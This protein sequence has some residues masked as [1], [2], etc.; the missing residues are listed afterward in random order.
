[1]SVVA[2][3]LRGRPVV[4]HRPW[5][6]GKPVQVGAIVAL[7][8]L[9]YRA[10]RLDYAW[11]SSLVWNQLPFHFD[12]F[13]IWLLDRR[14]AEDKSVVFAVFDGFRVFVD[15]LVGWFTELLFD[16]TWVGTVAAGTLIAL[17]FGGV[18]AAFWVLGAFAAF[19]LMGLWEESIQTLAL[20]LVA[21]ALSL[22]VG[23]PVGILA[24]RSRRIARAI[25]PALDAMQ[26]VPAFA[27]LMPVVILFSVGSA[28]AVVATM[29]YAIPPAV[30]ITALGIRRVPVN[31]VEAAASMGSTELQVLT[32]VQL[33]LARRMLLLGVN[34][35]ILF[36]L[37]MVVIAA[38]I[39]GAGLGAV[40]TRGLASSPA[41]A[42][43]GGIAIVVMAMA[44]DRATESVA[45][46]TDPARRHLDDRKRRRLR[47]WTIATAAA[48]GITV[49][50]ARLAGAPGI[51]PDTFGS[52][53][54]PRRAN[55][56]EWLLAR[57]QSVLDRVQDPAGFVFSVTEPTG[58]FILQKLLLPLQQFLVEGPWFATVAGLTA[59]AFV[60]SGLRPAL[61]TLAMLVA[62]GVL[63]VWPLAMDTLS[64]V[65]VATL[66]AIVLGVLLGI[67][68]AESR[69]VSMGLRP[70]ND[71]LQTLP[72][73]VY[74]VPFIYLMPVSIVPGIVA[75]VL[76]AFPVAARL[77][78]RGIRDVAPAPV[79]AADAFGATRAQRLVKV[80]V[81]LAGD[82][83]MLGV[84]QAI[85]MVLAVV[86][87]GGLVG[88]GG[89][90]YEVAQGLVRGQFGQGVV[91]SLA[92][93]ALG[94]ALDRV[95][96]GTRRAR[97]EG[98]I[99]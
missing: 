67:W 57:I 30:R 63:G 4:A 69:I 27:Y 79:E 80:K 88:S 29:I 61:T 43:L 35:T 70:V 36:A 85:I 51:Y 8:Y 76:Y 13:Q 3:R 78:E 75:G 94:I 60:V 74:I 55:A 62:I 34:Q 45:N 17:R 66:M 53:T 42:I 46:R 39:G 54:S 9:A 44:L 2:E 99:G 64:Q 37:S 22:L 71:V 95:T 81:P 92:I 83:I 24:G 40:V 47:L 77:V 18:R 32:K 68:A 90:G 89:L 12:E 96:Q 19:A 31:T 98:A 56:E 6:R 59:I 72:Q 84:N 48:V 58:I 86:V 87:I 1:V 73:L 23:M 91:A 38:L 7:M 33:P 20:M 50:V 65:L 14:A 15:D 11:P 10:W 25:T 28:A 16:L 52:E 93:L 5:W 97:Q 21:V 26:V 82:A 49:L 41:E